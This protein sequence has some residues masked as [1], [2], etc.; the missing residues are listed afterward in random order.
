M[1]QFV[2]DDGSVTLPDQ[3]TPGQ[4]FLAAVR[5]K[6]KEVYPD[7][8]ESANQYV[9]EKMAAEIDRLTDHVKALDN[10]AVATAQKDAG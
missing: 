6:A 8:L 9:F 7:H 2:P 1:K 5:K 10:L 3:T 4:Q